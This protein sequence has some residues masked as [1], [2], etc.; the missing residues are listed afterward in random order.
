MKIDLPASVGAGPF[1]Q[2]AITADRSFRA[3]PDSP[4]KTV[5]VRRIGVTPR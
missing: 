4:A 5:L 1:V 2:I 3:T